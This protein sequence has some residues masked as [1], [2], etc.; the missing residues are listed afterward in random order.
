M[1][2]PQ[3]PSDDQ[4]MGSSSLDGALMY[5]EGLLSAGSRGLGDKT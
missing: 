5:E 2:E 1:G 4:S 3:P